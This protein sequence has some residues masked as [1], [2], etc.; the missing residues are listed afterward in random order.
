MGTSVSQASPQTTSW[1]SVATCYESEQ[2]TPERGAMEVWRA[3]I[4][5]GTLATQIESAGVFECYRLAQQSLP[6]QQINTA[7]TEVSERHGNSMVLEFAKRATLVAVHLAKPAE[8]W[9]QQFF[10]QVT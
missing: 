7:L 5:A 10:R 6:A 8:Q 9:P 4:A 2:I 3:G 1:R